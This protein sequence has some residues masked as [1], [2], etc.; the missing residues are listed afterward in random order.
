MN[1]VILIGRLT[2]DPELA[3]TTSNTARCTFT[4]A[5]DR[6]TRQGEEKQA[7]FPRIIVWGRQAETSGRYLHKGSKC[8]VKGAIR[9]GSYKDRN[10]NTVYTTDIWADR[11]EFLE[12]ANN[13][14]GGNRAPQNVNNGGYDG[15]YG[16]GQQPQSFAPA[17]PQSQPRDFVGYEVQG[18]NDLPDTFSAAEDDI[19][20]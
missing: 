9:T 1:E 19:P 12:S 7:D 3:Y 6:P 2:K 20:F 10:G 8:A 5:V 4:L 13:S 17:Q 11:V 14:A 18:F 16:Q 15:G